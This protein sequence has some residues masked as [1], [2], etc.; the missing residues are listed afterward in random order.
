MQRFPTGTF[1]KLAQARVAALRRPADDPSAASGWEIAADPCHLG[2]EI[3]F[4]AVLHTWGQTLVHH[5]HLHCVIPWGARQ[6]TAAAGSPAA[7]ASSSPPGSSLATSA[8]CSSR[9]L[10]DVFQ[11]G[12]LHF[13]GRL[14][15]LSE[16]RRFAEHLRTARKTEWVVCAKRP[17]AGPEQVLDYLGRYTHQIA[18]S[19][20]R[21]CSLDDGAVR[22][23][24]TDYPSR[25]LQRHSQTPRSLTIGIATRR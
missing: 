24:Y 7:P 8:G 21:L 2:A 17:F 3:G 13:A 4:F 20:Q 9:G 15:P 11:S 5:P 22:L 1:R 19:N 23:R 14:Q 18:I 16:P 12:Q 25:H 10:R 6:T